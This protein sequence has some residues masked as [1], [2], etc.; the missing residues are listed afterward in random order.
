[1]GREM[2]QEEKH[3]SWSL[4]SE[5]SLVKNQWIDFRESVWRF[6]D[7]REIGPFYT[8]SRKDYVVITAQDTDGNYVCVRQFRQGIRE[9]TTEFPAGGI[10][11]GEEPLSA[12]K[13]ELSEE[14]GYESDEWSFLSK[15]PSYATIS[16]NYAYL[17]S[18]RNCRKVSG[19]HLDSIEFVDVKTLTEKELRDLIREDR[20]QQAVHILAYFRAKED[21]CGE[22]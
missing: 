17:F 8:G 7:G 12:A 14:T 9:V 6:P 21:L 19:Q 15:I 16:D 3:L 18:A 13:R 1:M 11:E 22:G 2:S 10:E 4:L 5:K 20:F